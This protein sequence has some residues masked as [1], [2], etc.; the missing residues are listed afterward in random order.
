M[1]QSTC[2]GDDHIRQ[3]LVDQNPW[4]RAAATGADPLAW[5]ADDPTLRARE[6]LD[7]GYRPT[8]LT[9]V[10]NDPVD[11]KLVVVRGHERVG[12]SVLVRLRSP[13][14]CTRSDVDSRQIIYLACDGLRTEDLARV[15]KLGRDLTRP[16]ADA[17]RIWLLDEVTGIPQWTT[18]VKY[19]R[20]NTELSQDTVICT[21]SLGSL[22]RRLKEIS[23]PE[24]RG[25]ARMN[26]T[27]CFC[28]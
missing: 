22:A 28:R 16:V 26:G 1:L 21:G 13:A 9:D 5:R 23:L 8:T 12:K 18:T 14:L 11:D 6:A 17:R 2:R 3:R 20:D 27:D 15:E 19:L 7:L 24:G 10:S 4:W 25:A